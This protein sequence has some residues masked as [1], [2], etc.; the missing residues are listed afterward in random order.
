MT[1]HLKT[2]SPD[3]PAPARPP[4]YTKRTPLGFLTP[5]S[6]PLPLSTASNNHLKSSETRCAFSL[7][8]TDYRISPVAFCSFL[9]KDNSYSPASYPKHLPRIETIKSSLS[10]LFFR[11]H[12]T[13]PPPVYYILTLP[14]YDT[15]CSPSPPSKFSSG[16]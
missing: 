2:L 14:F 9:R 5:G 6:V 8:V 4:E 11:L 10:F 7:K 12:L 16:L 3:M 13:H 1:G 15:Y